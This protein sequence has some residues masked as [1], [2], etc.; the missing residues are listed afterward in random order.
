MDWD[1]DGATDLVIGNSEGKVLLF[2]NEGDNRNPRFGLS[3]ELKADGRPI[4]VQ[5]GYHGIQ[6]VDWDGDGRL[7]LVVGTAKH[8]SIPVPNTGLP[9]FRLSRGERSLQVVFLR[10]VGTNT[11]PVYEYPRQFQFRGEDVYFGAHSN[12]PAVCN[13]GDTSGGPNLLLGV[14]SGRIIFFEHRDLTLREAPEPR[15]SSDL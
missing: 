1:G 4:H 6:V 5:P 15:E 10:N 8:A 3:E 7:D 9:W 11:V 12:S 13:L 2:T 14:E